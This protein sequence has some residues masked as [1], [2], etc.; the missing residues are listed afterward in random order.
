MTREIIIKSLVLLGVATALAVY[1]YIQ[2][3]QYRAYKEHIK[4]GPETFPGRKGKAR[5]RLAPDGRVFVRGELWKA[6]AQDGDIIEKDQAVEV[7]ALQNME[8]IVKSVN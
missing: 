1:A 5:T 2:V 8:L 7:V 4:T 6:R 3:L